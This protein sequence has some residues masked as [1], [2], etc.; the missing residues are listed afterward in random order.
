MKLRTWVKTML[1]T[2][3]VLDYVLVVLWLYML[4]IYELGL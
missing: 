3:L 2:W 1:I 4:R